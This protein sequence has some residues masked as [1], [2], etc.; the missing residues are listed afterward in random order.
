VK[1]LLTE[2]AQRDPGIVTE[3][4]QHLRNGDNV[5]ITSGLLRAIEDRGLRQITDLRLTGRTL[6]VTSYVAAF[7]AG[8][9][10][11]VSDSLHPIVFPEVHFYTNEDWAVLRGL[12]SGHGVPVLLMDN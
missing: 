11:E 5:V 1:W 3:I 12:S 7:G 2:A 9:G 10:A 6:P 4:E 8:A